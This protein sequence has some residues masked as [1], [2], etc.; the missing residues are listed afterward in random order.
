MLLSKNFH[1]TYCSNIHSGE[2]WKSHF[3]NIKKYVPRIKKQV[4]PNKSFGL[5]LR[6]SNL[7]SKELNFRNNLIDFKNWL[8][9]ENIYVFTMNGF[10]YGD[11]HGK[12]VKDLVHEPDWTSQKRIDYTK[13]LF[14]QLAYL[15]PKKINGG[16]S[17]SPISY[18]L[19]FKNNDDKNKALIKGAE[20]MLEIVIYLYQIE[21]KT[22]KYLHLDI[23][24]EPNG[25]LENSDDVINFF[26]NFLYPIGIKKIKSKLKLNEKK[27]KECI[28]KYLTICYD[29]CHF[30]LAY[31]DPI[32]TFNKFKT[33]QIKV[34]KIQVSSAL[35]II[36]N[37]NNENIIWNSLKKFDEPIYLH[38]VTEFKNDKVKT[39]KDLPE[40]FSNQKSFKE[41]R[42][43]FHVPIFLEKFDYLYS[44]QDHILKVIDYIN[45]DKTLC[46][47]LEIET[48]TWEVLPSSLKTE[49]ASSII[50]EIEWFQ[51]KF[52]NA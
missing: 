20:N 10:P 28:Q 31:E 2:D 23:E 39:F 25:L 38:Q 11:F 22:R 36:F 30:S 15:L 26:Q 40:L 52:L 43:H 44:T 6:L 24:P 4:S 12:K 1:L 29:I 3:E 9:Q 5:G 13:R 48:Y 17:S 45:I 49:I 16:I 27:A 32:H 35:K 42:A 8:D 21:K 18:K 41:L 50:R 14:D 34:G 7:A 19:W 47:H 33:Y 46:E 37:K 51:N